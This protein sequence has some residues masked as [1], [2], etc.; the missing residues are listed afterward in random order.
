[1]TTTTMIRLNSRPINQSSKE[2]FENKGYSTADFISCK[3]SSSIMNSNSLS[4]LNIILIP[5]TSMTIT[6]HII[7]KCALIAG[8]CNFRYRF[9]SSKISPPKKICFLA[10]YCFLSIL[11]ALLQRFGRHALCVFLNR[12]FFIKFFI[13]LRGNDERF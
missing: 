7:S 2:E 3:A 1:M 13:T 8:Y 6:Y 11:F 4:R 12:S 9:S 10:F 5:F